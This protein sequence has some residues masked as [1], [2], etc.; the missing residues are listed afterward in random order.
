MKKKRFEHS[1][2]ST[3]DVEKIHKPNEP[4]PCRLQPLMR[5]ASS[6]SSSSNRP[7]S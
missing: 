2:P 6:S 5:K 7:P 4:K 1:K 3:I